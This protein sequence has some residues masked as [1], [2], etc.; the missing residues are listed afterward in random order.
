MCR[1]C[2]ASDKENA[3]ALGVGVAGLGHRARPQRRW[4]GGQ[5]VL[6]T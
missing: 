5:A 3:A 4:R 2:G 1:D 6:K